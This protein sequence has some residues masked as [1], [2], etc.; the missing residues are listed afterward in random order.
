[1]KPYTVIFYIDADY[2]VETFVEHVMA[3]SPSEAFDVAVAQAKEDG[4]TSS[5]RSLSSD[6]YDLATEIVTF[7]GHVAP[8][9]N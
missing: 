9:T 1:M 4:G 3:T 2:A 5:G 7:D 6:S 8:S